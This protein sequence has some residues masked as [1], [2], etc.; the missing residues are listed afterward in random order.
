MGGHSGHMGTIYNL[1][2]H[3]LKLEVG[4]IQNEKIGG[5]SRHV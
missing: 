5:H 2:V 1:R 3:E 4:T